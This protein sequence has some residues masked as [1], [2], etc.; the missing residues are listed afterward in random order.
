[1]DHCQSVCPPRQGRNVGRRD[2][3]RTDIELRRSGMSLEPATTSIISVLWSS[4]L[5][6]FWNDYQ[7]RA[8]PQR[9]RVGSP[10][11]WRA[12]PPSSRRTCPP[13]LWRR[14][15]PYLKGLAGTFYRLFFSSN[16]SN[17]PVH[18]DISAQKSHKRWDKEVPDM[19]HWWPNFHCHWNK[20][21]PKT[22]ACQEWSEQ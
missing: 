9:R 19:D 10:P 11:F 20:Y 4:A 22:N 12:S 7:Y 18:S 5:R 2:V 13:S 21:K 6:W 14:L 17:P 16:S 15:T 3:S 8:P 1:M